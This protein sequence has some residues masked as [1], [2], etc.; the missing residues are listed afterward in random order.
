MPRGKPF[1]CWLS[2]PG[3]FHDV[4]LHVGDEVEFDNQDGTWISGRIGRDRASGCYMFR[5]GNQKK[6]VWMI[7]QLR[8]LGTE[9][10]T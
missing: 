7:T 8:P 9:E 4:A 6:I 5:H 2:T 1:I 10:K 3:H